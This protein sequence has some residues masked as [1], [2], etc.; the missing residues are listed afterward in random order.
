VA[1][2]HRLEGSILFGI[3]FEEWEYDQATQMFTAIDKSTGEYLKVPKETLYN[4]RTATIHSVEPSSWAVDYS[5]ASNA[6]LLEEAE[7]R[8]VKY[9]EGIVDKE[10][11]LAAAKL[12]IRQLLDEKEALTQENT[13]LHKGALHLEPTMTATAVY[14]SKTMRGRG[15][16]TIKSWE[17]ERTEN[18]K[19]A[20]EARNYFE[21]MANSLSERLSQQIAS[22]TA[23]KPKGST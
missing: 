7:A 21:G 8:L 17:E 15:L 16:L 6:Q 12:V 10:K 5:P 20:T 9:R 14:G 19:K 3:P 13:R 18:L 11:E 22:L 2:T 23:E 1:K 4:L